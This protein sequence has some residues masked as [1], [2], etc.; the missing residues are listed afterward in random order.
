MKLIFCTG[1]RGEMLFNQR[2][3]SRDKSISLDIAELVGDGVIYMDAYS[4]ELFEELAMNKI[5]SPSPMAKADEEDFVFI[6]KENPKS[7]VDNADTVI[8]YNFER[9]YPFDMKFDTP[10]TKLGFVSL[11]TNEFAGN[12]H[13]KI[14]RE[15]F[16]RG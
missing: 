1:I 4:E 7:L 11:G 16:V 12:S 2:R 5:I 3:V 10:L 6:E 13:E 15:V 14:T 8:I 9:R